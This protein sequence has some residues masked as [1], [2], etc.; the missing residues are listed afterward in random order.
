MVKEIRCIVMVP[1]VG[2]TTAV[3]LPYQMPESEYLN[4]YEPLGWIHTQLHEKMQLNPYD[5]TLH[6]RMMNENKKWDTA[7]SIIITLSFTPG[8]CLLTAYKLTPAGYEWG[9]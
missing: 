5:V 1:Q 4:D 9:K 6:S 3:T 7:K 8:S 2:G